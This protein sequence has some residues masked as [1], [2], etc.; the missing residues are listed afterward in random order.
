MKKKLTLVIDES[1]IERAKRHA[2]SLDMSVS[3]MV[4]GYLVEQTSQEGWEPPSGSAVSRLFGAAPHTT[5]D[6][7]IDDIRERALRNKHA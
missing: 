2:R 1:V 6:D 5:L 3:D 7:N 4:E